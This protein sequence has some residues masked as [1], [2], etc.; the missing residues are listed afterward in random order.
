M[1]ASNAS[2]PI[3][4]LLL[5][6]LTSL[7]FVPGFPRQSFKFYCPCFSPKPVIDDDMMVLS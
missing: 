2:V 7:C 6:V 5:Q 3:A 1:K 4:P